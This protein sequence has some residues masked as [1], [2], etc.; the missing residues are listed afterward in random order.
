LTGQTESG[1]L[2]NS[3]Q[4]E[5][6]RLMDKLSEFIPLE[7]AAKKMEGTPYEIGYVYDVRGSAFD[8]CTFEVCKNGEYDRTTWITLRWKKNENS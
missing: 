5:R 2:S 6:D 4:T 3:K 1:K 7:E 8:P